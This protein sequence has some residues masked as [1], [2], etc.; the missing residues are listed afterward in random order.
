MVQREA[1]PQ[2]A[3]PIDMGHV[4][5]LIAPAMMMTLYRARPATSRVSSAGIFHFVASALHSKVA[6][7]H[8]DFVTPRHHHRASGRAS[9]VRAQVH[10]F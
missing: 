9:L 5:A 3:G 1:K 6:F 4:Q 2:N 8:A 7:R 10:V